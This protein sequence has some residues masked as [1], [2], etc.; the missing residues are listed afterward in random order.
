M[1]NRNPS[2]RKYENNP[3]LGFPVP[4]RTGRTSEQNNNSTDIVLFCNISGN[5]IISQLQIYFKKRAISIG[6]R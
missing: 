4:P 3:S 6:V 2:N 1:I 5:Q